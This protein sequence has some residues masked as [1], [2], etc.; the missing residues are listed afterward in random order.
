MPMIFKAFRMERDYERAV[1][2]GGYNFSK[3]MRYLLHSFFR[4][5]NSCAV[6]GKRPMDKYSWR[7]KPCIQCGKR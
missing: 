6:C 5:N 4:S 7:N 3:L 2:K 1:E